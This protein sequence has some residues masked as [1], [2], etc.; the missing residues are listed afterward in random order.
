M[1]SPSKWVA[2]APTP[3]CSAMTSKARSRSSEKASG[4]L[5][6]FSRHHVAA[7][8]IWAAALRVGLTRRRE[9]KSYWRSSRRRA[10]A[11]TNSPRLASSR[12]ARRARCSSGVS[13]KVSSASGT[14]TV[15]VAPSSS[16]SPSS[17]SL[18][19][20]TFPVAIRMTRRYLRRLSGPGAQQLMDEPPSPVLNVRP[21]AAG[22]P[23]P[24][25]TAYPSLIAGVFEYSSLLEYGVL[26]V[27]VMPAWG[28]RRGLRSLGALSWRNDLL[29]FWIRLGMRFGFGMIRLEPIAARE[30]RPV[31]RRAGR[32]PGRARDRSRRCAPQDSTRRTAASG[33]PVRRGR[34]PRLGSVI[35]VRSQF[36]AAP[37][38]P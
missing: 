4:D 9:A 7:C 38:R 36:I 25:I 17:S 10:S 13:S 29:G 30:P 23:S 14:R 19:A 31:V 33:R 15:T 28:T 8:R 3:G 32:G 24:E 26:G 1:S 35:R 5:S 6:R 2:R 37:N 18:P 27:L 22:R 16:G 21:S 20:T 11:S 34:E 12:E